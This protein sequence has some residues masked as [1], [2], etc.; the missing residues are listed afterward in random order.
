[1]RIGR[2]NSRNKIIFSAQKTEPSSS[3]SSEISSSS[4]SSEICQIDSSQSVL[5]IPS[6]STF[7]SGLGMTFA[8]S[9]GNKFYYDFLDDYDGLPNTMRIF[10][11][12][13]EVAL[14]TW[15]QPY[16]GTSFVFEIITEGVSN[17][18]CGFITSGEINF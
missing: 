1:M 4:S 11:S 5:E 2:Q 6:G 10:I 18:Y 8:S 13:T 16:N 12:G 17:L 14:I 7:S 3:S 15:N 9:Q